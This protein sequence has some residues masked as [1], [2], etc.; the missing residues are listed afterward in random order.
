MWPECLAVGDLSSKCGE[1]LRVLTS[2]RE[3]GVAERLNR[4]L[5]TNL[6]VH[7]RLGDALLIGEWQTSNQFWFNFVITAC[8]W[9]GSLLRHPLPQLISCR[10]VRCYRTFCVL[11]DV[12]QG[13]LALQVR[14][15]HG[16]LFAPRK[17]QILYFP[18]LSDQIWSSAILIGLWVWSAAIAP[19]HHVTSWYKSQVQK[20]F[21]ALPIMANWNI[22]QY[23][24]LITHNHSKFPTVLQHK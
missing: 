18:S 8:G 2:Q 20:E 9:R 22:M 12:R 10:D 11:C 13:K 15:P 24:S 23:A 14:E 1:N 21:I 17:C 16:W 3:S 5:A 4:S 6:I 19:F 7:Q